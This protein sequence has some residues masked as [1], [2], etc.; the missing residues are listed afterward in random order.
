MN[1]ADETRIFGKQIN[2]N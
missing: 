1:Y 2:E